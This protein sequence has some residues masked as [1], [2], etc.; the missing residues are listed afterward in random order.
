MAGYTEFLVEHPFLIFICSNEDKSV[1]LIGRVNSDKVMCQTSVIAE[2]ISG[3]L[4]IVDQNF[5]LDLVDDFCPD[6]LS[7][8]SSFSK[9]LL[10]RNPSTNQWKTSKSLKT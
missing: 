6:F 3:K 4:K 10:S 5:A 1:K 8:S 7:V 9:S 2:E